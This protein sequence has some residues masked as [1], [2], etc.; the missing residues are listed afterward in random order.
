LLWIV[1]RDCDGS[2]FTKRRTLLRFLGVDFMF[3]NLKTP[4]GKNPMNH[5]RNLFFYFV[6]AAVLTM[7]LGVGVTAG[8]IL[9][10]LIGSV[11]V[12]AVAVAIGIGSTALIRSSLK[13]MQTGRVIQYS[14]FIGATYLGYLLIGFLFAGT[15][16]LAQP[17]LAAVVTFGLAFGS[18]TLMR[19]IPWKGRTWLPKTWPAKK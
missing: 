5:V 10:G 3:K 9:F 16:T 8:S 7:L 15:V 2:V 12:G 1:A 13:L 6:G 18:A 4:H 14:G 11:L 17:L 19:E